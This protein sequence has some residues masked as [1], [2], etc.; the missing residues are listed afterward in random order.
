[1]LKNILI[2]YVIATE[3][4]SLP[5]VRLLMDERMQMSVATAN[6]YMEGREISFALAD[7]GAAQGENDALAQELFTLCGRSLFTVK[8][9]YKGING[10]L[11]KATGLSLHKCD[12]S[13]TGR[14]VY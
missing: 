1:M 10:K 6:G 12:G 14:E 8:L 5:T 13:D 11:C 2:I 4:T 7:L 9:W 3:K